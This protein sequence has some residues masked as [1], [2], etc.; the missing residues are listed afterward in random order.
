M[1]PDFD[2]YE[3]WNFKAKLLSNPQSVNQLCVVVVVVKIRYKYILFE[4]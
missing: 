1:C 3:I 2:W 4:F